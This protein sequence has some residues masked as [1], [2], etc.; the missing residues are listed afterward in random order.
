MVQSQGRC[1]EFTYSKS[2]YTT[3]VTT[4][5]SQ[6]KNITQHWQHT[7]TLTYTHTLTHAI[8]HTHTHT[9]TQTHTHTHTHTLTHSHTYSHSDTHSLTLTHTHSHTLTHTLTHTHTHSQHTHR[10]AVG[11]HVI[12]LPAALCGWETWSLTLSE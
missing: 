10:L 3:K 2:R 1:A 9:H 4:Y 12:I 6:K 8:T 11:R 7:H 5:I